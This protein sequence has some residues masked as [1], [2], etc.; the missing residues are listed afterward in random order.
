MVLD[1]MLYGTKTGIR[2]EFWVKKYNWTKY[3]GCFAPGVS[4]I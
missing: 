4:L 2:D 3:L 1:V